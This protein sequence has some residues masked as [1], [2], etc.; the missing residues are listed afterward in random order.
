W[1]GKYLPWELDDA[2]AARMAESLGLARYEGGMVLEGGSIEVNGAGALLTTEQCLL[3]P[4]RN[5]ELPRAEI[6]RRL[7]LLFGVREVLWLGEGIIGDDTDGHIDD[8]TR[9]VAEDAVVTVVEPD[10]DDP[11]HAPLAENLA[12]LRSMRL[13]GER[14]LRIIELP[15][16]APLERE[17]E[18]LPASYGNF[19]IGNEVVLLPVFG[20]D[21]DA[22]AARILAGCFPDRRIVPIR[23]NELVVGLGAFHCLTQQVPAAAA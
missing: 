15:M 1:G 4:N 7:A 9:F 16:P 17:S 3:N 13:A 12:R 19:Y 21:R 18:R 6:E 23:A 22:Q 2:I 14:P 10:P 8:I 20:Q 5:P 11:N